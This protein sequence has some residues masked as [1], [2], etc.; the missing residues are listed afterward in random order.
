VTFR[1]LG[2]GLALVR[3][4]FGAPLVAG[5]VSTGAVDFSRAPRV[6]GSSWVTAQWRGNDVTIS[7]GGGGKKWEGGRW[8]GLFIGL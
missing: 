1:Q 5:K 7:S 3:A 4:A 2:C 6:V 8:G